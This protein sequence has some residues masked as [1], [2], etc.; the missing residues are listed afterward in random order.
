MDFMLILAIIGGCAVFLCVLNQIL[1]AMVHSKEKE[2]IF[3]LKEKHRN[4]MNFPNT[5]PTNSVEYDALEDAKSN[6]K[7]LFGILDKVSHT[8]NMTQNKKFDFNTAKKLFISVEE[9]GRELKIA[10]NGGVPI[11]PLSTIV[12]EVAAQIENQIPDSK[13]VKEYRDTSDLV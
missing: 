6:L 4:D 9:I 5:F 10:Q 13:I 11:K 12:H 2:L 7:R 3:L 1:K 8:R